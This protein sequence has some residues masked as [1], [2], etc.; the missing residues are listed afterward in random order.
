MWGTRERKI[1]IRTNRER[2]ILAR[3]I[4]VIKRSESWIF[5]SKIFFRK[6]IFCL[7]LL[8]FP[9]LALNIPNFPHML[10]YP[11]KMT[12]QKCILQQGLQTFKRFFNHPSYWCTKSVIWMK[13]FLLIRL[14][15]RSSLK[16]AYNNIVTKH[17]KNLLYADRLFPYEYL[18]HVF[19][20][21]CQSR[22]GKRIETTVAF[23][24]REGNIRPADHIQPAMSN[25]FA[26]Y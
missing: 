8:Q 14:V 19:I 12:F 25:F 24:A 23:N 18:T 10:L 6:K 15:Q 16:T 9:S 4:N 11:K 7:F 21:P 20:K 13:H 3:K 2:K 1:R 26:L 22:I 5:V 17:W